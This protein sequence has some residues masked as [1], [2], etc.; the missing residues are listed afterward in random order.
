M[1]AL[2]TPPEISHW[3]IL[4]ALLF[5]L[6]LFGVLSRRSAI[7]I[8]MAIEIMLN[9]SVLNF[10]IFNR[11][12]APQSVDGEVMGLFIIAVAAAEVVVALAIFIAL[13]KHHKST[14]V[15]RIHQ[16]RG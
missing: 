6:G 11:Y 14:D 4:S 13:F 9:A 8:L 16:L 3:L 15:S 10:A 5:S 12:L 2:L 1:N 7:A